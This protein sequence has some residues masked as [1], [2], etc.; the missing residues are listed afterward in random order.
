MQ[1]SRDAHE[2]FKQHVIARHPEE[3][4]GLLID[5]QYYACTNV[6]PE[7]TKAFR[8]SGAER[9]DKEL[10]I[11]PI[12]AVLHSHPYDVLQSQQ[13][14]KNKYN[15][16][17]PSVCDQENFMAGSEPW[18]IAASDG[19]GI[20]DLVWLTDEPRSFERR[21][22]EWFTSD[23]YA[24]VRDWY[25]INTEIR[26]PNF[27]REWEFWRKGLNIIEDGIKSIPFA[28]VL[29]TEKAQ[30]GDMPVFA[31]GSQII[32]HVSVLSSDN[33][34]LHCF[35]FVHY[36]VHEVPWGKWKHRAKYVVRFT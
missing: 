29:P 31:M 18:G 15:P 27:T 28:K 23:C 2:A 32:N 9:L 4:C 1:L 20:S 12:Q 6:H 25:T 22:F 30:K 11:G 24:V 17:W 13:F 5:N 34:M 10:Q 3:A 19:Q 16:A 35:P 7:P 8:I 21:Q 36:Y 33:M 14:Y 26:L